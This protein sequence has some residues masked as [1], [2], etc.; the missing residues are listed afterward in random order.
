L[1][2]NCLGYVEVVR[3]HLRSHCVPLPPAV[4]RQQVVPLDHSLQARSTS[5][6][7]AASRAESAQVVAP[8][9][10]LS[11]GHPETPSPAP[12]A[13]WRPARWKA[14]LAQVHVVHQANLFEGVPVPRHVEVR[15]LAVKDIAV[16]LGEAGSPPMSR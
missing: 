3:M 5:W 14:L 8:V 12:A 6:P 10:R 4:A 13:L 11:E 16:V 9:R 7:G 2:N 1:G 15:F